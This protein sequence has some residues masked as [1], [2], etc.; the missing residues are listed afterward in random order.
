MSRAPKESPKALDAERAL[1][2]GL[3]DSPEL[4]ADVLSVAPPEA[5]A[6]LPHRMLLALLRQMAQAGEAIDLVTVAE[7]VSGPP[8]PWARS[9]GPWTA[10]GS[11]SR[12]T[13]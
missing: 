9:G 1:L 13:P 7:R 2:G 11:S 5:M 10:P 4:L 12:T 8:G 3:I 6:S